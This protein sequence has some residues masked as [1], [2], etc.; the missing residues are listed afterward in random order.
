MARLAAVCERQ[1]KPDANT[2][3]LRS[4]SIELQNSLTVSARGLRIG[5]E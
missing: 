3:R 4:Q 2:F 1:G 5:R